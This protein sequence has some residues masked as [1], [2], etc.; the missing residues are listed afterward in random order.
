MSAFIKTAIDKSTVFLRTIEEVDE[1]AIDKT[2]VVCAPVSN[3][4]CEVLCSVAS[5]VGCVFIMSSVDQAFLMSAVDQTFIEGTVE[6]A[7]IFVF[8]VLD[9]AFFVS[10]FIQK[11]GE[12][13]H[14][15]AIN[16]SSVFM[17]SVEEVNETAVCQTGVCEAAF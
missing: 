7:D 5:Y 4:V 9:S 17:R 15:A 10:A 8:F 13:F 12:G 1:A 2:A 14:Q 11:V 6:V 16:K 3:S